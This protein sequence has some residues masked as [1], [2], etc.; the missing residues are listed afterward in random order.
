[1]RW[2]VAV[3]VIATLAGRA[4]ADSATA[5]AAFKQAEALVKEGKWAEACPLYEA[6]YQADPQLGALLYLAECHERIGK[7]ATAW[8]EFNDA[9][10]LARAKGDPREERIR[11]RAD[12]LAPKLAKI[13]IT[14]PK[15]PIPGLVVKRGN[16]DITVLVGSNL[17]ID[18][19]DHELTASA[20]GYAPWKHTVTIAPASSTTVDIPPLEQLAE[21]PGGTEEPVVHEGT[22]KVTTLPNAQIILDGE[23]V[24]TG[25]V[26]RKVKSGGHT[27]R[28]VAGGMRPYQ[29]EVL[30]SANQTRTIDVPLEKEVVA[31]TIVIAPR[32]EPR[33]SFELGASLAS[34]VKARNDNPMLLT[35]RAEIA[36]RLGRHVSFGLFGEY[37]Q[38]DTN[39]RCG[40]D[41]AGPNPE[42]PFDFGPR[43]QFTKCDYLMPGFQVDV[44]VM[45]ARRIDPFIGVAPGFRFGF[46][47]WT[48]Y[49]AGV[50][51]STQSE[52]F[53]AIVT[54][55]RAGV[56]YHPK[57][58]LFGW[59]LGAY[60]EASITAFG[61]E[62]SEEM[63]DGGT[64]FASYL[65]GIRTSWAF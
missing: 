21:Q 51:Q 50:P 11:K 9:I 48:P 2:L 63:R 64:S 44:H 4:H 37:G 55:I 16:V 6:S 29:T 60:I 40:F 49:V 46:S 39:D 65:G 15:P 20:P 25:S 58:G 35:M 59:Q 22:L 52:L 41:M 33:P 57:P 32:G 17:P 53:L 38:I 43:N 5:Q 14:A 28:V 8:A 31:S 36:L 30:V 61:D 24:G 3:L 23:V 34:G 45:P 7:T 18:P 1:M 62:A 56:S 47:D 42:T 27:L 19:G 54:S 26:E 10:D 13:V 12:S